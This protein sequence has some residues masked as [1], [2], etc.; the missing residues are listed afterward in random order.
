MIN[1]SFFAS[2]SEISGYKYNDIIN[3]FY[4]LKNVNQENKLH[5]KNKLI[6]H[7]YKCRNH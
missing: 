2:I 6:L 4:H 3:N 5:I 1:E 7:F